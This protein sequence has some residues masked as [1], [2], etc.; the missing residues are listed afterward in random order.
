MM[1]ATLARA[2]GTKKLASAANDQTMQPVIGKDRQP[3]RRRMKSTRSS[4]SD[5]VCAFVDVRSY[6]QIIEIRIAIPAPRR[7]VSRA[8]GIRYY[9]TVGVSA[10]CR[11]SDSSQQR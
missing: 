2:G 5:I 9:G 11:P 4:C 10:A 6:Q 7:Q 8:L 1:S 3:L